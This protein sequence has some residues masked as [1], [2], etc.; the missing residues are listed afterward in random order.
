M[1]RSKLV[2]IL[3]TAGVFVGVFGLLFSGFYQIPGTNF[4]PK[5]EL[6]RATTETFTTAVVGATWQA[7]AGVVSVD[8]ECWGAG[9]AGGG[10]TSD[11]TVAGSGGGGGAYAKK[12]ITVTP[13]TN[14]SYTVGDGVAGG[15][16]KGTDGT[17]SSFTGDA[18]VQCV[19]DGGIGGAA[20][21]GAAGAGGTL[22]N[23]DGSLEYAGGSGF[24]SVSTTGGGGG[25]SGGTG[26]TGNSATNGTGATAVTGGGPGGNGNVD[27]SNGSAPASGPGPATTS[28]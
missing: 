12:T 13:L 19:A 25:G 21:G 24:T 9:G 10:D 2:K 23:S 22:L 17:D 1:H 8:V 14:Y 28:P 27:G 18:A 26:S 7:P 11:N 20:N 15:T 5:P 16:G 6:A 3:M 4:P